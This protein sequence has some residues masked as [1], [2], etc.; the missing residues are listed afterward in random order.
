MKTATRRK[1]EVAGKFRRGISLSFC[2][3]MSQRGGE[4]ALGRAYELGRRAHH[5]EKEPHGDR[6]PASSGG[7]SLDSRRGDKKRRP[8]RNCLA[9]AEIS[10]QEC[11]PLMKWR[12][13]DFKMRSKH[14]GNSTK[15]SRRRSSASRMPYT[16]RLGS[17][18][19][20]CILRW[21]TS[22]GIARDVNK[23]S[24]DGLKNC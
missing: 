14:C 4:A 22:R 7:T 1:D 13:A 19:W 9:A 24:S 23:S 20:P 8:T 5:R 16:T 3:N 17:C 2:V 12:I 11:S 10:C 18:W 6:F 15:H 21:P